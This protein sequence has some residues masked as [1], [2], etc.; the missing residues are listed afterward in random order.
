MT[1]AETSAPR[2][3][4]GRPRKGAPD[5]RDAILAAATELF[6]A[7]G[8]DATTIRAIAAQAGVDPSLVLHYFGTKSDLVAAS[9][10]SPF[11][12]DEGIP[13]LLD[14]DPSTLGKR[15]IEYIL[16]EWEDPAVQQRTSLVLRSSLM[17]PEASTLLSELL[18]R[19]VITRIGSLLAVE[20]A[21]FRLGLVSS[22]I[23]GL[24]VGRYVLKIPPLVEASTADLIEHVGE[25]VQRYLFAD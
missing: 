22:Q 11:R 15:I 9:L 3:G 24:L 8:Y 21:E 2:R 20:D 13:P 10:G 18:N 4:R 7:Q 25:T 16:T 5:S 14:G 1:D 23:A 19:E 6:T 12:P 17:S